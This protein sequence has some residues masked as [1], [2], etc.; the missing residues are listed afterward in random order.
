[1][2]GVKSQDQCEELEQLR[3]SRNKLNDQ[4]KVEV[5]GF[6][7]INIYSMINLSSS[8]CENFATLIADVTAQETDTFYFLN[9]IVSKECFNYNNF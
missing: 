1:M 6:Y 2:D 9:Q 4:L 5:G 8:Q 3:L 7:L